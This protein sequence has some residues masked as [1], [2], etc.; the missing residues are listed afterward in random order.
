MRPM[1]NGIVYVSLL[2]AALPAGADLGDFRVVVDA[3][4]A[5]R[6][7]DVALHGFVLLTPQASNVAAVGTI[8]RAFSTSRGA[9]NTVWGVVTEAINLPTASGNVIGLE[10]AAANMSHDNRGAVLGIDVVFK[11]RMDGAIAA[12]IPAVGE[13]RFNQHSVALHVS[14]QPRSPAGEYSGWQTGI[15]F[16]A[17]SLDRSVEVPYAAGIDYSEARVPATFYLMVWRCGEV[18][19]GLRPTDAGAEIVVDIDR[20]P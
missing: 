3:P 5:A 10:A 16:A 11:N 9:R 15:K 7:E 2:L 6:S 17:A 19:C 8:G 1:K 20:A 13:N 4:R 18:K 12:A 14:A